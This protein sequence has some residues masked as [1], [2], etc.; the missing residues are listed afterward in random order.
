MPHERRGGSLKRRSDVGGGLVRLEIEVPEELAATYQRPGQ[1][2]SAGLR[3]RDTY[4]ALSG[5][6][7]DSVWE[8]LVRA[9]G[10]VVDALLGLAVGDEVLLSRALGEGFPMAEAEGRQLFVLATGSGFAAVRPVLRAR[11]RDGLGPSTELFL[12]VRVRKDVPLPD[13]ITALRA[14]GL[15]VTVCCSRESAKEPGVEH[16]YV[17]DA[18]R[19]RAEQKPG[20]TAGA[21]VFAA[22]VEAM[23]QRLRGTARDLHFDEADIRTNY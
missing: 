4:F 6:P 15:P 20:Q 12:G 18:L 7:G 16:G 17:Q 2:V 19:R 22:G 3:G 10:D 1:Y 23:V 11:A 5:E 21:I 8:V 14:Q 13:E 9:G